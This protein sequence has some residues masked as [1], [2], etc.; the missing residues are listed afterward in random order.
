MVGEAFSPGSPSPDA[1]ERAWYLFRKRLGQQIR[2]LV[3]LSPEIREAEVE[4]VV[5]EKKGVP[6]E[7]GY[8]GGGGR[9][10]PLP[11]WPGFWL[12]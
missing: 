6:P 10:P 8:K 12:G 4:V 7:G 11:S 5:D 3:L 9:K 1:R 2:S